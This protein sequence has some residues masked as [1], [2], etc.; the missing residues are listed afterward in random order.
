[1]PV[2]DTLAEPTGEPNEWVDDVLNPWVNTVSDEF[3][4]HE[5]RLD[6]LESGSS[7]PLIISR[8]IT[9]QNGVRPANTAAANGSALATI[10]ADI[11]ST[12]ADMSE[13]Y[14]DEEGS[15]LTDAT[16][17]MS[18]LTKGV[19]I[20]GVGEWRSQLLHTINASVGAPV[21]KFY[22]DTGNCDGVHIEDIGFGYQT[23]QTT[24][25]HQSYAIMIDAPESGVKNCVGWYLNNVKLMKAHIGLGIRKKDTDGTARN[26]TISWWQSH[27]GRVDIGPTAQSGL[28]ISP[29]NA[30]GAPEWTIDNLYIS[31]TY[32]AYWASTGPGGP[33][34]ELAAVSGKIGILAIEGWY[35]RAGLFLGGGS[36][37]IDHLYT[38]WSRFT[39]NAAESTGGDQDRCGNGIVGRRD[40]DTIT[41]CLAGGRR[42]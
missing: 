13:V 22:A 19:K 10:A 36:F 42:W 12:S 40:R 7:G 24:A 37:K 29:T 38:E 2:A 3:A 34:V 18:N 15:Y 4:L 6:D 17:Q 25:H 1:M 20:T 27:L 33:A 8:L 16:W 9:S 5:T 21:V 32:D 28:V 31:N 30:I 11:E 26:T 14:F 23:M 41:R 39:G 35:N